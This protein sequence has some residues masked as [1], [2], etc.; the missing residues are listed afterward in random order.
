M[1]QELLF[2]TPPA[3]KGPTEQL[4]IH[5]Q[6]KGGKSV[7]GAKDPVGIEFDLPASVLSEALQKA[8]KLDLQDEGEPRVPSLIS[9]EQTH[10][11]WTI[12]AQETGNDGAVSLF[13][14]NALDADGGSIDEDKRGILSEEP[15]IVAIPLNPPAKTALRLHLLFRYA[16]AF[17]RLNIFNPTSEATLDVWLL[18]SGD[19]EPS[20]KPVV[21]LKI[22]RE[23]PT[24]LEMGREVKMSWVVKHGISGKLLGPLPTGTS[25]IT[26]D[27]ASDFPLSQGHLMVR[28]LGV[29]T[30][31]LEAIVK[32][33]EGKPNIKVVRTLMLDVFSAKDL[34]IV[35]P[36][37]RSV[38]PFG[39][40]AAHWA[41]WGVRAAE[42]RVKDR[43]GRVV[44]EDNGHIQEGQGTFNFRAGKSEDLPIRLIL[45]LSNGHLSENNDATVTVM[46]WQ[47]AMDALSRDAP[48]VGF[49]Y[50]GNRD[51][52]RLLL[53]KKDRLLAADVGGVDSDVNYEPDFRSFAEKYPMQT[54]AATS[55]GDRFYLLGLAKND[56]A[57]AVLQ[58]DLQGNRAEA[59][60]YLTALSNS[61]KSHFQI[62]PM[63]T[64]MLVT[65]TREPGR[66][67]K[68]IAAVVDT[69]HSGESMD[70]GEELALRH[71]TD[72][73]LVGL[74]DRVYAFH[75]EK[76]QLVCFAKGEFEDLGGI[77]APPMVATPPPD[78]PDQ[79]DLSKGVLVAVDPVLV[80]LGV[81]VSSHP[82]DLVYNPQTDA[83]TPCGH[84]LALDRSLFAFRNNP[85]S[86][87]MWAV[88]GEKIMTL[89]VG[90][91]NVF[92]R[93]YVAGNP[94]RELTKPFFEK[95]IYL[96]LC[97]ASPKAVVCKNFNGASITLDPGEHRRLRRLI[98]FEKA[99]HI[100]HGVR[101]WAADETK[102]TGTWIIRQSTEKHNFFYANYDPNAKPLHQIGTLLP[103]ASQKF[104]GGLELA[105]VIQDIEAV[106][107][108][109]NYAVAIGGLPLIEKSWMMR[110]S[111]GSS[112]RHKISWR[113]AAANGTII[114]IRPEGNGG[115]SPEPQ[116]IGLGYNHSPKISPDNTMHV[117][118]RYVAESAPQVEDSAITAEMNWQKKKDPKTQQTYFEADFPDYIQPNGFPRV[119]L[120]TLLLIFDRLHIE[121]TPFRKTGATTYTGETDTLIHPAP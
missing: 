82:Q 31:L 2:S 109:D 5:I 37:P 89:M 118:L 6:P 114:T 84:G 47:P 120:P 83:W 39:R 24:A 94:V 90:H 81:G 13:L 38:L 12:I 51:S 35:K 69:D 61:E 4:V 54:L 48:L 17:A 93:D 8:I 112:V 101:Y 74:D 59:F 104:T 34:S 97:N 115:P 116:R 100:N 10:G 86:P 29:Q 75:P 28:A 98:G 63:G 80:L 15:L 103:S 113:A 52:G 88:V 27:D 40:V 19:E 49:V 33:G 57:V 105:G 108:A 46:N 60:T 62:I 44:I 32:G 77:L 55:V 106:P 78:S 43:S 41:A 53:C 110:I 25:V 36:I 22:D 7:G 79:Y 45:T 23:S 26:L 66:P 107:D 71:F 30:Y 21:S 76:G 87:R 92:S 3:N 99:F 1:D 117:I 56:G 73:Q 65:E 14:T 68:N 50:A 9:L 64:R 42:I 70:W 16:T 20:V 119:F 58:F 111:S 67:E 11:R 96:W 72:W 85:R 91:I 121:F 18:P 102:E 95:F